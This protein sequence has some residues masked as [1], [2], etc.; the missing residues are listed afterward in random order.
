MGFDTIEINVILPNA[1][2][3]LPFLPHFAP[4]ENMH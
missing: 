3:Y 2:D 1:E 4:F